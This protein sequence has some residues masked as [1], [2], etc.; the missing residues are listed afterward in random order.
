MKNFFIECNYQPI[1][2]TWSAQIK[3]GNSIFFEVH[4]DMA[5]AIE[6]VTEKF[7]EVFP[8][9]CRECGGTKEVSTSEQVYAGEPHMADIGTKPCPKC[10][11]DDEEDFDDQE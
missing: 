11:A 5:T 9:V 8:P 4:E 1:N 7:F 3:L 6:K 10:C 2:D